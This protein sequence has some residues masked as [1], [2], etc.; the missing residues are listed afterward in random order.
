[1]YILFSSFP[2]LTYLCA[3]F[4]MG[5]IC[6][7]AKSAIF[8]HF[9]HQ[10]RLFGNKV[11]MMIASDPHFYSLIASFIQFHG[12]GQLTSHL[13]YNFSTYTS[14]SAEKNVINTPSQ[15]LM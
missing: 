15:T 9:D 3:K 10:I 14:A 8:L 11:F 7:L 2:L 12:L 1:M 13:M 6:P 4:I 5:D